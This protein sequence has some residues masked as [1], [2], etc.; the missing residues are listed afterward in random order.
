MVTAITDPALGVGK[1]ELMEQLGQHGIDS[2]PFFYPLSSLPA[3]SASP[4]A[5]FARQRNLVSYALSPF[6]LNLPSAL[7][8]TRQQVRRVCDTFA[9][10]PPSAARR[11]AA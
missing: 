8:L 9:D 2:R 7:C 4:E 10:I 5:Q 11:L 3:Y 6:G 1:V